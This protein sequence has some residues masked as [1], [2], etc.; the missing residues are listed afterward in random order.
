MPRITDFYQANLLRGDGIVVTTPW[1]DTHTATTT[2]TALASYH[3]RIATL[4]ILASENFALASGTI[5]INPWGSAAPATVSFADV[6]SMYAAATNI[7]H[8]SVIL[9]GGANY[10]WLRIDFRPFIFLDSAESF[11]ITHSVGA[12]EHLT[13]TIDFTVYG[14]TI[15]DTDD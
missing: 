9:S 3:T 15:S 4:I 5:D 1:S 2:I 10:H 14:A 12:T 7:G 13:G 11:T 6:K 8:K